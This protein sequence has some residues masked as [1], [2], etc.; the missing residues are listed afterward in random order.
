MEQGRIQKRSHAKR[1]I[2]NLRVRHNRRATEIVKQNPEWI[3]KA[4]DYA[5]KIATHQGIEL[6]G[7]TPEMKAA[8]TAAITAKVH[9]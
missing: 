4:L 1:D 3:V 6:K 7:V 9:H 2:R 5:Q 8:I